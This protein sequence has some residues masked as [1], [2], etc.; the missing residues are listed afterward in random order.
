VLCDEHH[1]EDHLLREDSNIGLN[2]SQNRWAL[3]T[4][5]SKMTEDKKKRLPPPPKD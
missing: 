1:Y 2:K 4:I 5:W 3:N